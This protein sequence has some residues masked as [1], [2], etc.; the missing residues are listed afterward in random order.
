MLDLVYI[1]FKKLGILLL[2]DRRQ[3]DGI[4]QCQYINTVL[5]QFKLRT[6]KMKPFFPS[7]TTKFCLQQGPL[8]PVSLLPVKFF[9]LPQLN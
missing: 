4:R 3:L 9:S 5:E 2:P 6:Q 8:T 1:I 7:S